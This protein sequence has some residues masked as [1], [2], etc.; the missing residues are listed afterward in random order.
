MVTIIF[1][2]IVIYNAEGVHSIVISILDFFFDIPE[3]VPFY[4]FEYSMTG[5]LVAGIYEFMKWIRFWLLRIKKV[6]DV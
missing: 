6:K 2:P 4:Q 1:A 3:V 5:V